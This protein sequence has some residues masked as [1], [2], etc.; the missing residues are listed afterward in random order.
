MDRLARARATAHEHL[1]RAAGERAHEEQLEPPARRPP[2]AHA[3]GDDARVVHH[4]QVAGPQHAGQVAHV[5]V[6]RL[7]A[8]L[9]D[10]Q[11]RAVALRR[12]LLGDQLGRQRIVE[13]RQS[14]QGERRSRNGFNRSIGIGKIVVELFPEAIS[15]NVCR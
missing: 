14:H 5:R 2:A 3:R 9:R 15:T 13:V 7:A 11:P 10:Q 8:A 6:A 1:P 12:R 4:E